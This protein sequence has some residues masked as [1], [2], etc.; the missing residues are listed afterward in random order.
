MIVVHSTCG[1]CIIF[2]LNS[3][4]RHPVNQDDLN[5]VWEMVVEQF[6]DQGKAAVA[7]A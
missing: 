7:A 6:L 5:I 1:K 4:I 2:C 3:L